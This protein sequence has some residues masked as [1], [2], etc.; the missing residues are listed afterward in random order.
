MAGETEEPAARID[1]AYQLALGRLPSA[2]ERTA[3]AEFIAR[4]PA[5]TALANFCHVLLSIN[6]FCYID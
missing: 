5:A 2:A 1:R 6:E 3:A 4:Q